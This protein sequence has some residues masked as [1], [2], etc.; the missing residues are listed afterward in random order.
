MN[1][2]N[3]LALHSSPLLCTFILHSFVWGRL[4]NVEINFQK[5]LLA[6]KVEALLEDEGVQEQ[7]EKQG[8]SSTGGATEGEEERKGNTIEPGIERP[9]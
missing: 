7:E 3:E 6:F 4:I 5:P 8:T 2:I 9:L 1:S